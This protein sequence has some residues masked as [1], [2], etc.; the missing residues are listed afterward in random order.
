MVYG[1]GLLSAGLATASVGMGLTALVAG[2]PFAV[3]F[4][5]VMP[6][7]PLGVLIFIALIYLPKLYRR[8]EKAR[9]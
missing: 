8:A 7:L 3:W 2:Q 9:V 6:A 1:V 5:L 4:F